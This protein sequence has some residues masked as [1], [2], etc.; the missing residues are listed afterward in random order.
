[1]FAANYILRPTELENVSC[2]DFVKDY[3]VKYYGKGQKKKE[4]KTKTKFHF[5]DDHPGHSYAYMIRRTF[6]VVPMISMAIGLPDLESL[7]MNIKNVT[8][9]VNES[10]ERY[11]KFALALI[12]PFR[13]LNDLKDK[14]TGLYWDKFIFLRDSN[15]LSKSGLQILQNLQDQIQ[16][17]KL[18]SIKDLLSR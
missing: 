2:F 11:A 1:M 3:E 8:F 6:E 10:R 15:L 16:C 7:Q 5:I 17:K 9:S 18:K 12:H 4:F 13:T 14:Q